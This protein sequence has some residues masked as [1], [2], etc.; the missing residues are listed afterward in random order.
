MSDTPDHGVRYLLDR[1]RTSDALRYQ[2]A[3]DG[4]L[5][6]AIT[7]TFVDGEVVA[8]APDAPG[9]HQTDIERTAAV[10]VRS[11]VRR[12]ERAGMPP[13]RRIQRWRQWD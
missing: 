12:A 3:L 5:K 2:G 13:P 9:E 8:A 1:D 4:A 10:M 6:C 11:A 7:V